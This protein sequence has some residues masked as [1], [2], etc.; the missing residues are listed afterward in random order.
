MRRCQLDC[1][2]SDKGDVIPCSLCPRA[3]GSRLWLNG[4]PHVRYDHELSK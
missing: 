2:D 4:K 3:K 1:Y